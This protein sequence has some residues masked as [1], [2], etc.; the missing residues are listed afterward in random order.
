MVPFKSLRENEHCFN[1]LQKRT[2]DFHTCFCFHELI[3]IKV[4]IGRKKNPKQGYIEVT[5]QI[6]FL[7][8]R[9]KL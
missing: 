2:R 4:A 6:R 8:L 1:Q 9:F 7:S 5:E 3:L